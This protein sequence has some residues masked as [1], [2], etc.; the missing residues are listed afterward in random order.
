MDD[1]K[2]RIKKVK[3]KF[4]ESLLMDFILVFIC[5]IGIFFGAKYT[6]INAIELATSLNVPEYIIAFTIIA[7]GTSLPELSVTLSSAR[8]GLGDILAGNVIGS[9]IANLLLVGGAASI[10]NPLKYTGSITLWAMV[11]ITILFLL[12]IRTKWNLHRKEGILF[13]SIYILFLGW[14]VSTMF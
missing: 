2:R 4:K 13:L 10:I 8:K 5:G 11:G 7:I 9:N 14:I 12:L 3:D 1:H 6:V